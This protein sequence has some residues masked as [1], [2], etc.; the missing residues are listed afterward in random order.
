M[1][2]GG[3]EVE[4]GERLVVETP[5]GGL[6]R[7]MRLAARRVTVLIGLVDLIVISLTLESHF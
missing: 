6:S 2:E 4:D 5:G 1:S 7:L 3:E